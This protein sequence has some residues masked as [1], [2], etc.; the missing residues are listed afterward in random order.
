MSRLGLAR[1]V[2]TKLR[3]RVE[4]AASSAS[5]IW[6]RRRWS[7][8]RRS[9]GPTPS[10]AGRERVAAEDTPKTVRA[11]GDRRDDL[12]GNG[13]GV[14]LGRGDGERVGPVVERLVRVL[15]AGLVAL[16]PVP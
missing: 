5:S 13:L 1:P 2:S 15:G 7:R 3:C 16:D 9:R 8:Q 11:G 12:A 10:G 4:T 14:R 6:L